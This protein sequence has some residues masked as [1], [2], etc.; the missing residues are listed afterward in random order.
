MTNIIT[1][2]EEDIKAGWDWVQ[3]EA[4]DIYNTVSPLVAAPLKVFEQVVVQDLWGAAAAFTAKLIPSLQAVNLM[5]GL[6]DLE[7]A[8]LNTIEHLWPNL[9]AAAQALGSQLL[10]IILG[11]FQT[12]A[13]AAAA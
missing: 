3:K 4:T 7:T 9:L 13:A 8:F 2:V 5:A 6:A 11:L 10:Q 1:V 12:K